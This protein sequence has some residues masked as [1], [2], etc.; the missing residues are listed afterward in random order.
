MKARSDCD[1][2][3]TFRLQTGWACFIT[4]KWRLSLWLIA[5]V[6]LR[7]AVRAGPGL[8]LRAYWPGAR[9]CRPLSKVGVR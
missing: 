7:G 6:S 3:R 5:R 4:K 1:V 9:R 8:W 2:A